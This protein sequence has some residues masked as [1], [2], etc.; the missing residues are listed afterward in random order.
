[1]QP[2]RKEAPFYTINRK[3]DF[4]EL[5][6]KA[7]SFLNAEKCEYAY[8]LEG[9]D[10]PW[11]YSG[12]AGKISYSNIPPGNY[13]LKVKWSNGEGFW[14]G[15]VTLFTLRVKQYWWLTWPAF[16]GYVLL[17]AVGV[18]T[19][20]SIRK[21]KIAMKHELEIEH[22]LSNNLQLK[23]TDLLKYRKSLIGLLKTNGTMDMSL[24]P[25]LV[26]TDKKFMATVVQM[27][28][29]HLDEPEFNSVVLEKAL[30]MS[31]MQLYRKL[32]ALTYMTPGEFIK[33]VRLRHAAHLLTSTQ[34]TVSEIFYRTGFNNQSYF[35]REFKKLYQCAP[36][37]YRTQ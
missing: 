21:N 16:L 32:K 26:D 4:F 11:H 27:I 15:E 9:F 36:N 24:E 35:F 6:I 3:G 2:D 34:L 7:I 20:Y 14:T 1:V 30:N 28:E 29:E 5:Q 19:I 17:L 10:R 12:S 18:Y 31:K 22:A 8:Y 33:H 25:E 37:E 23:V 13:K